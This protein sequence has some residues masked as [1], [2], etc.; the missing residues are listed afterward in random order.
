[1]PQ[2]PFMEMLRYELREAGNAVSETY[3]S[4][5]ALGGDALTAMG[6][7]PERATRSCS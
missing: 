5:L 6:V 3:Y 7:Y 4:A 1:M 2:S